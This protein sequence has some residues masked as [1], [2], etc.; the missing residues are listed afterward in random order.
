V[1]SED[2]CPEGLEAN[3]P[4]VAILMGYATEQGRID[5]LFAQEELFAPNTLTEF[6][7]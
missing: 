7:I 1:L 6:R 3:C 4:N 2:F 5:R